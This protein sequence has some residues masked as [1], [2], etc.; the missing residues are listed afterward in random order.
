MAASGGEQRAA[1]GTGRNGQSAVGVSAQQRCS[2]PKPRR[3]SSPAQQ[4]T[5]SSKQGRRPRRRRLRKKQEAQGRGRQTRRRR[6]PTSG[7]DDWTVSWQPGATFVRPLRT[8]LLEP[9]ACGAPPC[10]DNHTA[11]V[12]PAILSVYPAPGHPRQS[13]ASV[14]TCHGEWARGMLCDPAPRYARGIG[15]D[16]Q[17][18]KASGGLPLRALLPVQFVPGRGRG[19]GARSGVSSRRACEG[20]TRARRKGSLT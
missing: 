11:I 15:L 13:A 2:E 14:G 5:A 4:Q 18:N 20:G 19:R 1:K 12:C 6:R 9:T 8:K 16:G 17:I 3:G 7:H 10:G